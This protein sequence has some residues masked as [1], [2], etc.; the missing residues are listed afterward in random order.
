MNGKFINFNLLF[1]VNGAFVSN[2]AQATSILQEAQQL[3][4]NGA[5]GV[6]I[7]YSANYSQTVEIQKVYAAGGWN[8]GTNGGNQARVMYEM[9]QLEATTFQS[10]QGI[11]HIAP[12]TT[13]TQGMIPNW[14]TDEAEQM[15]VVSENLDSIEAYLKRGWYVLGWQNQ[16]TVG[17][18]HPYAVGGG[19]AAQI[20]M[21]SV[22]AYIQ[23]TLSGFAATYA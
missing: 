7:T 18:S 21:P 16:A 17:T 6:A 19:F 22:S 13:M 20:L 12:I 15:K 9:E 4:A 11:M 2:T 23:T 14:D 8:T 5:P 3:I 1:E 10:L